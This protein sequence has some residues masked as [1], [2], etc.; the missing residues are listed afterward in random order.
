MAPYL[1]DS[2]EINIDLGLILWVILLIAFKQT[3]TDLDA[4]RFL[5]S[6][7]AAARESGQKTELILI[8]KKWSLTEVKSHLTAFM[9]R[10]LVFT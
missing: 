7:E 5:N 6:L 3:L 9:F 2:Y 8:W 1:T 10:C 4:V